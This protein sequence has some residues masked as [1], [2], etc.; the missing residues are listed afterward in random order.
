MTHDVAMPTLHSQS[1]L[2][3]DDGVHILD[4]RV[5]PFEKRFVACRTLD[6]VAEAIEAMVTQSNGPYFAAGGGMVLAARAA[7]GLAP[8]KRMGRLQAAADRLAR[9][10]PTNNNIATA[11]GRVLRHCEETQCDG[12]AFAAD[13]EAVVRDGW[14][15]RREAVRDVGRNAASVIADGAGLMTYCWSEGAIM[16]T[17]A[18]L[19]RDGKSVTLYCPETR[20]YLQGARLTAH[21]AAEMGVDAV[22][23]TDGM[24]AHAMAE[25][26]VTMLMTA[27]D[28]VTMS[29]HVI[30]KVGTLQS[31]IAARHFRIPYFATVLKPDIRAPTPDSVEMEERDPN[32]ALHCLGQ[33]TASPLARGWYPAFDVTPP[34]LV[35]GIATKDGVFPAAALAATL[36]PDPQ[37]RN[38]AQ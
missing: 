17:L 29:G 4:R 30:N 6:A 14:S 1:V 9:T 26:R 18:C 21:S 7:Q 25:G 5:F 28:R 27:A 2:L 20:P 16:E 34:E 19:L 38:S 31:A 8:A 10:R 36:R 11:V 24:G 15:R 33:R 32:E 13:I 23:M 3:R 35:S 37:D 22:V 12:S